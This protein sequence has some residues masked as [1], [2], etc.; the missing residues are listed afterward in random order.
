MCMRDRPTLAKQIGILSV[1]VG[2]PEQMI[3]VVTAHNHPS[4]T[5]IPHREIGRVD[6]RSDLRQ[7]VPLLPDQRVGDPIQRR[8]PGRP[9]L[10]GVALQ[11]T[12]ST[13]SSPA[14][15]S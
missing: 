7:H 2:R 9:D 8:A 14:A 6:L 12:V 1:V 11:E 5:H 3:L 10:R 4:T 13:N 15:L